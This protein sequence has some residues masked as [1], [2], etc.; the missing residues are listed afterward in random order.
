MKMTVPEAARLLGISERAVRGRIQRGTLPAY[1]EGTAWVV[2]LDTAPIP[3]PPV[4]SI[5]PE[6]APTVDLAPLAAVI[7]RLTAENARLV[8]AATLWQLRATQAERRVAELTAGTVEPADTDVP[9]PTA[10]E[11]EGHTA[12]VPRRSWWKR[13][14]GGT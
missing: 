1:R 12:P 13:L 8:E 10:P 9:P 5:A 14:L 4:V 2:E 6:P 7:D 11:P 3:P